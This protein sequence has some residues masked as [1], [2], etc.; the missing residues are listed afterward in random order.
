MSRK[1]FIIIADILGQIIWSFE[2][3]GANP[4]QSKGAIDDL[5]RQ[6]NPRYDSGR[7]WAEIERN[8]LELKGLFR[9]E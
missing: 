3:L 9:D 6:T 8:I 7:F 5:L 4:R 1:D 2:D